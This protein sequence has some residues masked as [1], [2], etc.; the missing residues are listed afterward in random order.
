M[1]KEVT[2]RIDHFF[3]TS[4]PLSILTL[5]TY[6][7]S[8]GVD[9]RIIDME[10]DYGLP[11]NEY[12]EKKLINRFINDIFT[13]VVDWIG[14]TTTTPDHCLASINLS[15]AVK[16]VDPKIPIVFGGYQATITAKELLKRYNCIDAI[17]VGEGERA[18]FNI[19]QRIINGQSPFTPKIENLAFRSNE[20]IVVSAHGPLINLAK[21]PLLKFEFLENMDKYPIMSLLSSRGCPFNCAYCTEQIMRNRYRVEPMGK[22]A[23]QVKA[24]HELNSTRNMGI[25]DPLFGI[26]SRRVKKICRIIKDADYSF[27]YETR[28]DVLPPSMIPEIR[29]AG[30]EVM[31]L[32]LESASKSTL[33]RMNKL[34]DEPQYDK[35]IQN[36]TKLLDMCFQHDVTPMLSLMLGYPGDTERDL[37]ST[38]DFLNKSIELHRQ[39]NPNEDAGVGLMIC[40]HIVFISPQS[41]LFNQLDDYKKKGLSYEEGDLFRPTRVINPSANLKCSTVL[42]YKKELIMLSKITPKTADRFMRLVWCD[43]KKI[44]SHNPM[45]IKDDFLSTLNAYQMLL[46]SS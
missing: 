26:N 44:L 3:I 27:A 32:G 2:E 25:H 31:L 15:L 28:A 18:S 11:L 21:I 9:V 5:G 46:K 30:G 8:K 17:I 4:P 42:N 34:A 16:E 13:E 22:I 43:F 14:F 6:L 37:Q 38:V 7:N 45:L 40:P 36:A 19:H 23:Q 35:Y 20:S 12:G 29:N 10:L 24:M 39:Y 33:L 41:Q 1:P